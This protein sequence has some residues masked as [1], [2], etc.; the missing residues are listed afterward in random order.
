LAQIEIS[1]TFGWDDGEYDEA[2]VHSHH[3][4]LAER[5][6]AVM[7]RDTA[8]PNEQL[9]LVTVRGLMGRPN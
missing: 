4:D 6:S 2:H 1:R 7:Q 9:N 5:F 8:S 3:V